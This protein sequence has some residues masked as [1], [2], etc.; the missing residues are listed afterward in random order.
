MGRSFFAYISKSPVFDKTV[1]YLMQ[2]WSCD[3]LRRV[4][5]M[6]LEACE[7]F[8]IESYGRPL[9]TS[10]GHWRPTSIACCATS[11]LL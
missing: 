10:G 6:Y 8:A 3:S 9:A 11:C 4:P 2:W 5:N 7:P 1:F